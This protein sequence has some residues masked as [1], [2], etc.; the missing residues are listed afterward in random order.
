MSVHK[1]V[2]TVSAF[3]AMVSILSRSMGVLR[4]AEWCAGVTLVFTR[5]FGVCGVLCAQA[6]GWHNALDIL[7]Q[8]KFAGHII[9]TLCYIP[10]NMFKAKTPSS[11]AKK[12]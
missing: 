5:V 2:C 9:I 4:C 3:L 1:R 10:V 12:E 8:F 7:G 11:H 6:L